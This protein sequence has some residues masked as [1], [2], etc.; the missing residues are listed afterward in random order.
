VIADS[1]QLS[2]ATTEACAPDAMGTALTLQTF[3][4]FALTMVSIQG[5]PH[6]AELVGWRSALA[7]LGVGPL[8]GAL[9]FPRRRPR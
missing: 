1:A 7:V 6:V 8:L 9:A 5:L 2:A 3:A 4:G